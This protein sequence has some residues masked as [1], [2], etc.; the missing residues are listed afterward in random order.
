MSADQRDSS[1]WSRLASAIFFAAS[2][3][4]LVLALSGYSL[5]LLG[6]FAI[7]LIAGELEP[8]VTISS[9][10]HRW[11]GELSSVLPLPGSVDP[12]VGTLGC[13]VEPAIDFFRQPHFSPGGLRS[14]TELV[15]N[16][17][18]WS[19]FGLAITRRS[20]A[21]T[22]AA[23]HVNMRESL[24]FARRKCLHLAAAPLSVILA[25]ILMAIPVLACS[26]LLRTDVG[27]LIFATGWSLVLAFSTMSALLGG[28]LL[29]CWPL[30]WGVIAS[31]DSDLFDAISRS[32]AYAF[33]RFG[34]YLRYMIAGAVLGI[35]GWLLAAVLAEV[36]VELAYW[37]VSLGAGSERMEALRNAVVQVP[38]D[39]QVSASIQRAATIIRWTNR[40]PFVLV[41]AYSFSYFWSVAGIAYLLLR[42]D[43]DQT[44]MDDLVG[45][46]S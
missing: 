27:S 12:V 40:I 6:R 5:I 34:Y 31:E 9:V 3:A 29:L 36:V 38:Q 28:G 21:F 2:P 11:P 33:Q 20:V 17:C 8:T 35:V 18:V 7:S 15:W 42:R 43:T 4:N 16:M 25:L 13:L 44:R 10:V 32:Y 24:S 23:S 14:V 45:I 39:I 46:A 19:F 41:S 26:W 22:G 1:W 37:F 30:M